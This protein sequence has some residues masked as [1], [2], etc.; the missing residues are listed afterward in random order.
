MGLFQTLLKLIKMESHE[1]IP[2]TEIVQLQLTD[3]AVMLSILFDFWKLWTN[4]L[5]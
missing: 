2:K 3:T 5:G 1:L 4:C